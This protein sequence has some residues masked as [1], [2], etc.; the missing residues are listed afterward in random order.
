MVYFDASDQ[1]LLFYLFFVKIL[2]KCFLWIL[3]NNFSLKLRIGGFSIHGFKNVYL[4]YDGIEMNIGDISIRSKYFSSEANKPISVQLRDVKINQRLNEDIENDKNDED[5]Y[6]SQKDKMKKPVKFNEN[7]KKVFTKV[8]EFLVELLPPTVMG[9][10]QFLGINIKNISIVLLNKEMIPLLWINIPNFDLNFDGCL[11]RNSKTLFISLRLQDVQSKILRYK[12]AIPHQSSQLCLVEM[13]T[14]LLLEGTLTALKKPFS[15]E[16]LKISL[17]NTNVTFH[18]GLF[19]M[20]EHA[21]LHSKTFATNDPEQSSLKEE[22]LKRIL[23]KM[24]PFHPKHTEIKLHNTTLIALMAS[25]SYHYKVQLRQLQFQSQLNPQEPN[26]KTFK[27]PEMTSCLK[28]I[29]LTIVTPDEEVLN[30]RN[31]SSIIKTK[32]DVLN[33]YVKLKNSQLVYVHNDIYQWI[34]RTFLSSL[35]SS[36]REMIIKAFQTAYDKMVE[37]HY[38]QQMQELFRHV[39]IN[40]SIDLYNVSA[41]LHLNE[42]ISSVNIKKIKYQLRQST[43]LQKNMYEDY[44]LNLLFSQRQWSAG[45]MI[46]SLCYYLGSHSENININNNLINAHIR[47][48]AFFIGFCLIKLSSQENSHTLELTVDTLRT[49]Y[50]RTLSFFLVEALQSY[51]DYIDLTKEIEKKKGLEISKSNELSIE[52]FLK[53]CTEANVVVNLK[54]KDITCFFI[55]RHEICAFLNLSMISA[56]KNLSYI[57]FEN[58]EL[59]TVDFSKYESY[60]CNLLENST[61]YFK[62][63]LIRIEGTVSD[64]SPSI[65]I[66]FK[67]PVSVFW[68]AHFLRHSISLVRDFHRLRRNFEKILEVSTENK[69]LIPKSL[70]GLDVKKLRNIS[71][72]H[73]DVNLEK[74]ITIINQISTESLFFYRHYL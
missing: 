18:G 15:Y 10:V 7:F 21:V 25:V 50:S 46:E 56:A 63:K 60:A 55:N 13:N 24:K 3:K 71:L 62:T 36:R 44:T 30:I 51:K 19:D 57:D 37:F 73:V 66:D 26:G 22:K 69:K 17:T 34:K 65:T 23:D 9:L 40:V 8:T 6:A 20:I 54:V 12:Q 47:G 58:I 61:T 33:V 68:N 2:P 16:K 28:I 29:K 14:H 35:K 27:L 5:F 31:C 41:V 52:E 64:N 72:R 43:K 48:S 42:Q 70:I 32:F 1:F 59:S 39:V 11:I 45:L 4:C 74:F 38:S 49:E 53:K 67:E